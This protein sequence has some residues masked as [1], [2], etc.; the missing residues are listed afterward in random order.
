MDEHEGDMAGVAKLKGWESVAPEYQ[1]GR[2]V[3]V[4]KTTTVLVKLGQARKPPR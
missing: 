1:S 4:V 3:L 2:A